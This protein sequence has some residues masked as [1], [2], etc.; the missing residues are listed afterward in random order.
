M[1]RKASKKSKKS[2]KSK[3]DTRPSP[4]VSAQDHPN[5]VLDGNDGRQ[6]VSRADKKG[7]YRWQKLTSKSSPEEYYA[8]L[9][10]VEP[11]VYVKKYDSKNTFD[12]L[13][14]LDRELRA[15]GIYFYRVGWVNV[16]NYSSYAWDEA[17]ERLG[18]EKPVKKLIDAWIEEQ[19]EERKKKKRKPGKKSQFDPIYRT[20]DFA[21]VIFVSEFTRF[22]AEVNGKLYLQFS[23]SKPGKK[24]VQ[25]LF[26]REFGKRFV[27]NGRDTHALMIKLPRRK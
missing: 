13:K 4:P 2:K 6:Y 27:W 25:Q 3:Y 20:A 11:G 23:L 16:Y 1:P 19:W 9:V 14:K 7:V 12:R 24:T 17:E 10:D 26:K 18:K 5:E 8:Q 22:W 15:E 21:D